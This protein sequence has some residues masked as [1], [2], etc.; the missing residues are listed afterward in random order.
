[1]NDFDAFSVKNMISNNKINPEKV[2]NIIVN[3]FN[4][5]ITTDQNS[6]GGKHAIFVA[7]KNNDLLSFGRFWLDLIT[8]LNMKLEVHNLGRL[9]KIDIDKILNR[10]I[11]TS[12]FINKIEFDSK[13][14]GYRR[15]LKPI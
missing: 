4:I 2:A 1:M 14:H 15:Y 5:G 9:N 6:K 10:V 11:I 3:T 13:Y 12:K 8:L 7:N